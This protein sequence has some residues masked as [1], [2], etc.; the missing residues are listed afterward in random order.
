MAAAFVVSC[1]ENVDESDHYKVPDWLKG[2][3]YE[4]L[5][6][7]GGYTLFLK[8]V[9]LTGYR[10]IVDGKSILTVMAP[11]DNAFQAFLQES[12]YSSVEEM[13]QSNPQQ[14]KKPSTAAP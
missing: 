14:L 10:D 9:E 1:Q 3:A 2:N 5:Q 11:D 13:Y 6:K 12:G 4:V 8:A 7:E